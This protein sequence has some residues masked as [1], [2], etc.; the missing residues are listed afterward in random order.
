ML[1]KKDI[2]INTV[3]QVVVRF[4]TLVFTL[5]SIKLLTNYLGTTG[6]GEY[7][8]ITTYVNFFLVIAD[9]GLFSV[10]V[11]EISKRPQDEK[12]ILSNVF[13]VRLISALIVSAIA[14]AIVFLTH[15]DNRI[16]IG[17][18]IATGFLFFNL[19]GSIYDIVLQYR[20]KMQY[21]ALAEFLSK[22]LSIL[23]LY[24]IIRHQGDFLLV[25]ATIALSGFL[26]FAFK[27]LFGSHFVSFGPKYN[28]DI[29]RWIFNL[30]WPMGIV[31][32]V[33]NLFFKL[34]TLM[35][36]VLKGASE[37][38]IYTVAYKVLEVTVFVGAYFA[39][40]LKPTISQ[41]IENNKPY[42]EKLIKKSISIM[43]FVSA[44]IAIVSI[45]FSKEIIVFLSNEDFVGG[46]RAL[47]LLAFTLPLIYL[48]ALLVEI[49][50]ANDE[51]KLLVR[52]ATFILT[53]NFLLNLVLIPR[54]SFM[55][56]A[57][58]TLLSEIVLF[59][60]N[61]RYTRR[62][63]P[64]SIDLPS[65]AKIAAV[66]ILTLVAGFALKSFGTYFLILIALTFLTYAL[67]SYLFGV[68]GFR[69]LRE[70]IGD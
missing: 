65:I 35:L 23:A 26:I 18:T 51:R 62:I 11:R 54:Y 32:I 19:L 60:I 70:A 15:Y 2:F 53:F 67:F 16:K 43:L 68:V 47:T 45:V 1:N 69:S 25:I 20:L 42:I 48:D 44:P 34:D 6:V 38:G 64:Y 56:A 12:K 22:L 24:L 61:L 5:I 29:S 63:I 9:L 40:A 59:G 57:F 7:N 27:W 17:V 58:V 50:I 36:F 30:A 41:N 49:L 21:S 8:T 4:T 37:T 46:G 39:S 33:S 3:S 52:I 66:A 13:V 31:F 55:G 14:I 10:T 28:R